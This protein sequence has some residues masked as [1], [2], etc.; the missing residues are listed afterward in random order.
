MNTNKSFVTCYDKDC[1]EYAETLMTLVSKDKTLRTINREKKEFKKDG[2]VVSDEYVLTIGK[3]SS[4]YNRQNFSDI[5]F[6]YGIHIGCYGTKAWIS[7]E[8]FEWDNKTISEFNE[9]LR[10]C[11]EKLGIDNKKNYMKPFKEITWLTIIEDG[12]CNPFLIRDLIEEKRIRK[13]Q[14]RF[15][16]LFFYNCYLHDFLGIKEDLKEEQNF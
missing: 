3:N 11:L 8:K 2:S 15:A 14:Y 7:C 13:K 10:Y 16:I 4:S 5:Y 6:N 12:I 9:E 1:E